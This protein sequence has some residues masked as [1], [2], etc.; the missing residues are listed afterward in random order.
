MDGT[1][2]TTFD[3]Y[4]LDTLKDFSFEAATLLTSFQNN[5]FIKLSNLNLAGSAL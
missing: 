1:A 3:G 4:D 2:L 5:V